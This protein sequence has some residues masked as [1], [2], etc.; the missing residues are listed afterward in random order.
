LLA[1]RE[2][3][4]AKAPTRFFDHCFACGVI[5]GRNHDGRFCSARC[6]DRY[7]N[8]SP[9]WGRGETQTK[10]IYS[11][12]LDK[13]RKGQRLRPTTNGFLIG[14]AN[15]RKEFESRGLRCCSRECERGLGEKRKNL[16]TLAEVGMA[17]AEKRRCLQCEGIIPKW[18]GGRRTVST[19]VFCSRKCRQRHRQP[20]ASDER[21]N[22]KK[23]LDF[24]ESAPGSEKSLDRPPEAAM[25]PG[26]QGM[27]S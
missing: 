10:P 14:C 8:G 1:D 20:K 2:L 4:A 15:C 25:R 26:R 21:E 27:A 19:K 18:T 6:R 3:K 16:E 12:E 22:D 23:T 7:D 5:M 11:H 17:P 9:A 24:I 13:A